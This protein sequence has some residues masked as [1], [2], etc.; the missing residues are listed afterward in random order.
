MI[1]KEEAFL[2]DFGDKLNDYIGEISKANTEISKSFLFLEFIRNIFKNVNAENALKSEPK[3]EKYVKLKQST[4]I[5]RGRIDVLLGNIIIEFKDEL[6]EPKLEDALEQLKK[7]VFALYK[8]HGSIN[9]ILIATDGVNLKA[10]IPRIESKDIASYEQIFL[11]KIDEM[12]LSKTSHRDAYF[13]LDRYLLSR[14]LVVPTTEDFSNEFGSKSP[15]FK[16]SMIFLKEI[17]DE[18]K[19]EMKVIY[20]E[21]AN[22]L[23][24]VYGSSVDSEELFLKHTYLAT[25]S[26]LMVYMFY[27]GGTLPTSSQIK[28]VL[29]GSSFKEWGII[30]FL[31]E[32]FFVW[33]SRSDKGVEFSKKLISHLSRFD[34]T[35]LN[36][37]ILKGLYQDLVDPSDRHDLG[38]Y[39]TPDW[40]AEYIV[41]NVGKDKYKG[42]FLDPSCGSGTF[43]VAVIKFKMKMLR[44][45]E[46]SKL[47]DHI[48]RTVF[49][50]DVHP[51]ALIIARSNY[52][53]ALGDL[54][55][56]G[57]KGRVVIPVY[58]SDS[59]KIP[60][61]EKDLS[62]MHLE[63]Y[64]RQV[65][66][67]T[68]LRIP[69]IKYFIEKDLGFYN[70]TDEIIEATKDYSLNSVK[71][72]SRMEKKEF[73]QFLIK[74]IPE[75]KNLYRQNIG[76][77]I[78]ELFFDTAENMAKLIKE[79]KDTIWA[80]I[81]KNFYKPVLIKGMFDVVVGNP[82]WLSYRYVRSPE[83]QNFLKKLIISE[84]K[85]TSKA[86]L[87][88]QM[89]LAT[90][91]FVRAS[92]IYLKENG[93]IA[94][95]MPRSIFT[96]D[97]HDGFRK[98]EFKSDLT[99]TKLAD[100]ENVKPLFNVP[101]C[102]IF[103]KR[104]A[105]KKEFF[106]GFVIEG[107]L[108]RKNAKLVEARKEL[109]FRERIKFYVNHVGERSFI[110]EK[111]AVLMI[112]GK[113]YYYDKF[114]QGAT[115]VPRQFWFIRIKEHPKFGI[116]PKNP[117]VETSERAIK[118]AKKP[119]NDV[120]LSGN[121]ESEFI[122]GTLTGSE[123]VPFGYLEILPVILP[124]E[125]RSNRFVLL[126]KYEAKKK[127]KHLSEWLEKC[128][129]IWE[130][131]RGEKAKES[132][133]EW[134][135]YR[136]KLTNQ[137]PKAKFKVLYNTSGTNLV[138]CLVDMRK[139]IKIDA[140][141]SEI[142][143]NGLVTDAKSY[144]FDC[145]NEEESNYIVSILNSK[146][147]D[148]IIKP[149]QSKG[150]FGERD[151]HKKPLEIAIPKFD[152]Q[153]KMHRRLIELGKICTEKTKKELPKLTAKY[154]SIGKIRGIIRKIL[155]EELAE[156]DELV[157]KILQE[158]KGKSVAD[159][160]K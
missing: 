139:E 74:E 21:W 67:K 18:E 109:K 117:Y 27:S 34:L 5:I 76:K 70:I 29:D 125:V 53:M 144:L 35:K 66:E 107:K 45:Y 129:K 16:E 55:K 39:Y 140:N 75:I 106:D 150:Q 153:N 46:Q 71:S 138:S 48:T 141:G 83:Y 104:G 157:E 6:V 37:D 81:L 57:R 24:I 127:W 131:K 33:V 63:V 78:S 114:S 51:L 147:I 103:G 130:E 77:E 15:V 25:L 122:F 115:I 19:N 20:K 47:L 113:S 1:T 149:M 94:F 132:S 11:D 136:K 156:I 148:E 72:G 9:Y 96:G 142:R 7:Y 32:D 88:T 54:L 87:I 43:I 146:L 26:K 91:F 36:E 58:L 152:P 90:L 64:K 89:E 123:L 145:E 116:N 62:H 49:G 101:S 93:E 41:E 112:I 52:I 134:L 79:N 80:F 158:K 102:V 124:L 31:E 135:D 2:S 68:Y 118:N 4:L 28:R 86:E 85:L 160:S 17:W 126:S 40:L 61:K 143:L 8:L 100:L 137:N 99:I 3:M 151:I 98:G 133:I 38:E 22:Y 65:D 60:E 59:L 120:K 23:R 111:K 56:K 128:E 155:K 44:N 84:Y 69:S 108:Q 30:N 121:I 73:E 14:K 110:S 50:I 12:D 119:Y 10:Y 105:Q 95:V 159:Y 42:R 97:Q 154:K 92:E 13:W 82:P